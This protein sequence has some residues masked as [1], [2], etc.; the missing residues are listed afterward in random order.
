MNEMVGVRASQC[1]PTT[2]KPVLEQAWV[3]V[4]VR[5]RVA[6]GRGMVRA[7]GLGSELRR[8]RIRSSGSFRVRVNVRVTGRVR[9][10]HLCPCT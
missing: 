5:F 3:R 6:G 10:H 9:V 4:R 1:W 2:L 8:V 7:R